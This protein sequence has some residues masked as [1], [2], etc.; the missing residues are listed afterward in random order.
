MG[1]KK[2]TYAEMGDIMA[3]ILLESMMVQTLYHLKV[4]LMVIIKRLMDC[5]YILLRIDLLACFLLL[6]Q[7]Q[8]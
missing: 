5:I 8:Q 4:M 2:G 1:P 6:R 3:L 7:A